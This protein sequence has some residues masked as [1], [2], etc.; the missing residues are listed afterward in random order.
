[1]HTFLRALAASAI[2]ATVLLGAGASTVLAGSG[3]ATPATPDRYVFDA[4]WC[5]DDGHRIICTTMNGSLFV[6]A[7]PDGREM[8]TIHVRQDV[9]I[10]DY[11]GARL[12][13]YRT[14]SIDRTVFADGGQDS[15]FTVTHTKADGLGYR[16]ES[17]T[18]LKV[19]DY[20]VKVEKLTGPLCR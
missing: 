11:A 1:M 6:V 10:T 18:I 9:E 15:T 20:E 4:D 5:F 16:C 2:L 13:G 12:G 8:A 19:V 14:T 7:T 17:T 3:A